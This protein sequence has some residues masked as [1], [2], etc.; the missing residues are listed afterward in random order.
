MS[1]TF[2]A[3][4]VILSALLIGESFAIKRVLRCTMLTV[5]RRDQLRNGPRLGAQLPIFR[6]ERTATRVSVSQADLLGGAAA[7][8]F[9]NPLEIKTVL[10]QTFDVQ[11]ILAAIRRKFGG[12]RILVAC[13]GDSDECNQPSPFERA[14]P[15]S[16]MT[17]FVRDVD[18]T[19]AAKFNIK[20]LPTFVVS[21]PQGMITEVGEIGSFASLLGRRNGRVNAQRD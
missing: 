12:P 15:H 10:G 13:V 1:I 5:R 4:Y 8:L 19:L 17:T 7:I 18:G 3:S 6:A 14:D 16:P 20:W 9:V 11:T 2:V 21:D